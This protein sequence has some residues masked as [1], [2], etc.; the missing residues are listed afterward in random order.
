MRQERVQSWC[1]RRSV[2]GGGRCVRPWKEVA[3][4][5]SQMMAHGVGRRERGRERG[6][7][8]GSVGIG[9]KGGGREGGKG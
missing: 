2:S 6:Q 9:S 1:W 8:V 4:S 5:A 3:H 7:R